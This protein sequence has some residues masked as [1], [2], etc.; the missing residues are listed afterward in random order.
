MGETNKI[1]L[2]RGNSYDGY[3]ICR[4]KPM[5]FRVD[6]YGDIVDNN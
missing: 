2:P 1:R 5:N 6:L 4:L 3:G